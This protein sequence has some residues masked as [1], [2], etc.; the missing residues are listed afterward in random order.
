MFRRE[1]YNEIRLGTTED[2]EKIKAVYP[3][4]KQVI[5]EIENGYTVIAESQ[6]KLQASLSF[7]EGLYRVLLRDKKTLFM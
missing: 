3:H 5:L 6:N 4:T 1:F 7:S 2:I